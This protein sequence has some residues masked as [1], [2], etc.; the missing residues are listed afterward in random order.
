MPRPISQN[1]DDDIRVLDGLIS[2]TI[3]S[4]DSYREAIGHV[5]D[6]RSRAILLECADQRDDIV[7]RLHKHLWER[8]TPPENDQ[9]AR[10]KSGSASSGLPITAILSGLARSDA[11]CRAQFESALDDVGVSLA[12]LVIVRECYAT[13]HESVEQLRALGR[14]EKPLS[15]A[16]PS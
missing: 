3:D 11:A 7:V 12:T 8:G 2:A 10:V 1:A 5:H 6:D 16:L 13:L 4:A 14:S 15:I 9:S